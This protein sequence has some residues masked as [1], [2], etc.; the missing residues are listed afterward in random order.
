MSVVAQLGSASKPTEAKIISPR[1][2]RG[3]VLAADGTAALLVLAAVM[4][5]GLEAQ[6][7]IA[8]RL[9]PATNLI[10]LR[11]FNSP[12]F[13]ISHVIFGLVAFANHN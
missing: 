6:D 13:D 11:I 7:A 1:A 10:I 3:L 9:R 12:T 2:G 4:D 5:A 8:K